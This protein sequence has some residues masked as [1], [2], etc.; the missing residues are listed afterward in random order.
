[1]VQEQKRAALM[2]LL[3]FLQYKRLEENTKHLYTLV[4]WEFENVEKT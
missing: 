3:I 1:M 4:N 2:A